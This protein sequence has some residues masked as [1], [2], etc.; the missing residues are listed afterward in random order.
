ML[1]RA[2]GFSVAALARHSDDARPPTCVVVCLA[3]VHVYASC[4]AV[5]VARAHCV[6]GTTH[7]STHAC[8]HAYLPSSMRTY[9]HACRHTHA[10]TH[11][12][13]AHLYACMHHARRHAWDDRCGR[14]ERRFRETHTCTSPHLPW[15]ST[16]PQTAAPDAPGDPRLR[17]PPSRQRH[18][19]QTGCGTNAARWT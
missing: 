19:A 2:R 14:G 11:T 5:Y 9:A 3:C 10:Y 17:R 13:Y 15:T 4:V 1:V 7:A 16:P 8:M 18:A 12:V 6:R